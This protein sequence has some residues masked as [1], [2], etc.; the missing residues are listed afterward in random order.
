MEQ[1]QTDLLTESVLQISTKKRKTLIPW[2]V[3]FFIWIFLFFGTIV[4]FGLIFGILG[5]KFQLSIY[6]LQTNEPISLI[7]ISIIVIFLFKGITSYSLL[8][9]KVWAVTLGIIDAI[10][11]ISICSFIMIYPFIS[12]DSGLNSTFS[13]ELLLLIPYLLKM[14]KIKTDW[15]QAIDI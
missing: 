10:I 6:G 12:P 3:R 13:I 2:W 5:Y 8:K 4:P 1:N 11:G 7:G 9:Q 14:V 15:E